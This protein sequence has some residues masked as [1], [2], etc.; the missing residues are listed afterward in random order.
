M[1]LIKDLKYSYP[2][3]E[4]MAIS[5]I[6]TRI[7]K[8]ITALMG[9]NGSGKTSLLKTIAGLIKPDDGKIEIDSE[10][11]VAFVPENPEDG[12]FE[13]TVMEEVEFFPKNLELNQEKR[14]KK[15][16]RDL[17]I[18]Q[19]AGR[20]PFTLSAGEMRKVSIA[21]VLSGNP[22]VMLLDEPVKS[23][24][25]EGEN[26]IGKLLKKLKSSTEI[27]LAT[28]NSNFAYEFADNVHIMNEGKILA[29]GDAQSI[30]SN[31]KL[32][33]KGGLEI[34]DIVKWAR[35]RGLEPPESFEKALE[36]SRR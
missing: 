18:L 16:L 22:G 33:R 12:F 7:K 34:P 36:I 30:L 5:G 1:I 4:E 24:H 9:K 23:L 20:S 13:D 3:S 27:L 25:K 11:S 29:E 26:E 35:S 2:E 19:L 10:R 17:D 32:C 8:G 31:Q 15:A 6:S 14:A 28:H 21:S